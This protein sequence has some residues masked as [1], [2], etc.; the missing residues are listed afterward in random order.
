MIVRV[1][2]YIVA[3]LCIVYILACSQEDTEC[4][5]DGGMV[6]QVCVTPGGQVTSYYYGDDGSF[7]AYE[8][9]YEDHQ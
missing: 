9:S 5:T 6:E 1:A 4:Y 2:T 7:V 8:E 3:A